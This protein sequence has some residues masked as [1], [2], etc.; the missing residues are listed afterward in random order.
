MFVKKGITFN[1]IAPGPIDIPD[2]GW[3]IKKKE[4]KFDEF[5][6]TLI[7]MGKLGKPEDVANIVS[8]IASPLAK[9]INGSSITVDGGTSTAF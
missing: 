3:A 8:F 1:C 4:P 7:P 2:T 6:D 5:I 9:F